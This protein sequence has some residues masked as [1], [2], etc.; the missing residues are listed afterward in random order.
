MAQKIRGSVVAS[1]WMAAL[2]GI[3]GCAALG[4]SGHP[5]ETGAF[6]AATLVL[7]GLQALRWRGWA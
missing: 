3:G 5:A 4:W 6:A 1:A 7:G 2:L